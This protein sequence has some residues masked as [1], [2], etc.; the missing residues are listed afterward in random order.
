MKTVLA[1]ERFGLTHCTINGLGER[2]GNT[3]LE[4]IV[5]AVNVRKGVYPFDL[6]IDT[7]ELVATSHMVARMS[8]FA[9]PPNK[10]VV[11]SNA[12]S[13][14]SGMHQDAL[15]K[16]TETYQ[17]MDPT[18]VGS[19]GQCIV[20]GPHSGRHGLRQKLSDLG[21]LLENNALEHAFRLVK[22]A[23]IGRKTLTNEELRVIACQ[24]MHQSDSGERGLS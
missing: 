15:L 8:G 23:T 22:E 7:R 14:G 21:Y 12:F 13:H 20:I 2:A 6:R 24:C 17:I 19:G 9:V 10:A 4:E 16:A 18:L 3:S 11:G 5:M 1:M